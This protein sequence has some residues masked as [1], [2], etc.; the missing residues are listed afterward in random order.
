MKKTT[1]FLACIVCSI[2]GYA[3]INNW[4]FSFSM[5]G[6]WPMGTFS[7]TAVNDQK[8]GYSKNGFT[9]ILDATYPLNEHWGLKAMTL[10]NSNPI[11]ENGLGTKLEKRM[12]TYFTVSDAEREFLSLSVNSWMWNALLAGPEYSISF[13]RFFWDFHLLGGM[14]VTYLPQQ[15]LRYENPG[16]NWYY[17]DSNTTTT[18]VS[19]GILTGT[20]FR[21][22]VSD[23]INLKVG[24]DYYWSRARIKYHQIKVTKQGETFLTEQ[25]GSGS[26]IIPLKMISGTIGFVY[27]LN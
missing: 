15:K 21:F 14:N 2:S 20:A 8:S 19:H 23:R 27:Y 25:L 6:S 24:V 26:D 18:D 10:L 5:G 11:D 9:L 22:P 13:N 12:N 7:N 1:V 3:Q 16:N 17:L 4:Y